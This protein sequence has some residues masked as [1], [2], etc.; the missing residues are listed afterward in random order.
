[1]NQNALLAS[2][3]RIKALSSDH[4]VA[5]RPVFPNVADVEFIDSIRDPFY[6]GRRGYERFVRLDE[7]LDLCKTELNRGE[8]GRMCRPKLVPVPLRSDKLADVAHLMSS[9]VVNHDETRHLIGKS[10]ENK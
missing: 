3:V 9:M 2:H 8:V 1:M 7:G 4:V 10:R 5:M 6:E